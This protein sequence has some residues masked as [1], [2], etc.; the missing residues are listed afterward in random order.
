MQVYLVLPTGWLKE[1]QSPLSQGMGL[2]LCH[3][4]KPLAVGTLR[5]RCSSPWWWLQLRSG[6]AWMGKRCS[7]ALPP[8]QLLWLCS[9]FLT[10]HY[11]AL[12]RSF[13]APQATC[14]GEVF[15]S[16]SYHLPAWMGIHKDVEH[17]AKHLSWS[18]SSLDLF[19]EIASILGHQKSKII[20]ILN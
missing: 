16:K 17:G 1:A 4:P 3:S 2:P 13:W 14:R 8:I 7:R 9:Q 20:W 11:G 5:E 18:Y 19:L 15:L 12:L 10:D 6:T